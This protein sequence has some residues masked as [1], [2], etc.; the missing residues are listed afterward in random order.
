M[1]YTLITIW[2]FILSSIIFYVYLYNVNKRHRFSLGRFAFGDIKNSTQS[3]LNDIK[4]K[5][6]LFEYLK[7]QRLSFA[8]SCVTLTVSLILASILIGRLILFERIDI[9][10]ISSGMGIAGN[11]ALSKGSLKLYKRASINVETIL[12]I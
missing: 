2:V 6:L 8:L 4:E 1:I 9:Q 7:Q 10:T 3:N 11:I 5:I 12:K